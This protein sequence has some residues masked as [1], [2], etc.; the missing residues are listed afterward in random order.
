MFLVKG[1]KILFIEERF[2]ENMRRAV[3][4]GSCRGMKCLECPL[5]EK[6]IGE[7]GCKYFTDTML[8]VDTFTG[9]MVLERNS[10]HKIGK[11]YD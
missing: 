5:S 1:E 6:Y 8:R 9:V 2:R 7:I 3:E 4:S 11:Y 10:M